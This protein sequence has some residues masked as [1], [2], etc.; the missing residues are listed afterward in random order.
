MSPNDILMKT[1]QLKTPARR[2]KRCSPLQQ[3]RRHAFTACVVA[4]KEAIAQGKCKAW[5]IYALRHPVVAKK[6]QTTTLFG[7]SWF[8]KINIARIYN[9]LEPILDPPSD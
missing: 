7:W 5:T 4:W 1:G 3:R 6:G 9:D 8:L 2:V